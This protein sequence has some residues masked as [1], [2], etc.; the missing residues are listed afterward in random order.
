LKGL[1]RRIGALPRAKGIEIAHQLCAGLAA[2]HE[3]GVLHRDLKPANIMLDGRGQVRI[4]DYGLARSIGEG[5]QSGEVAG[6][7][8]YMA[9]EQLARGE[10]SIQSDLYAIGL[11]LYE[12]FTGRRVREAGS[13]AELMRAHEDSTVTPPSSFVDDMDPAVERV[14]LRCMEK[15]PRDRPQSARAVA[16]ALPGGDP[17]AAA[18]V[19]GETPT[20]GMV[21]AAGEAGALSPAVAGT[22]L[23]V[24]AAGAPSPR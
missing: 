4:T 13:F 7:P 3:R 6:T 23:A 10:T 9:P 21:A 22:C 15:D 12:V 18:L 5:E 1:L 17:L 19:A 24:V 20:P 14:I 2:A 8:A 11:V 16:S